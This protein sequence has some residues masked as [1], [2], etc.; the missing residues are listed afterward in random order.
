MYNYEQDD[1]V[2]FDYQSVKGYGK[3]CGCSSSEVPILGRFYIVEVYESEGIDVDTY[4][5]KCISI[6]EHCFTMRR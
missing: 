4:P 5:F 1:M 6:P 2:D 3:I